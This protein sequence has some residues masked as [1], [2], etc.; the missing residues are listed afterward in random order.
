MIA[1]YHT[2]T[3]RCNHALGDEREYIEN[4]IASGFQ[5][6]GFSDHAPMPFPDG[7]CSGFRMRVEQTGEYVETLRMLQKEYE[8]D[9]RILIGFEAEYYPDV[10]QDFLDL[11]QPFALDYLI[12]GQHALDNEVN[13]HFNSM[14]TKDPALLKKYV[15]Q[16]IAGLSTGKFLYH[17]H[18]DICRFEGDSAVFESEITRYLTFCK[19]HNIPIEINLLGLMEDR[20]YPREDLWKLAGKIGVQA[21]IGC[22]A[23]RPEVM[24]DQ[25]LH[26][27]GI[28]WAKKFGVP[29]LSQ[30][31]I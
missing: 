26:Q 4:A 14:P 19:E 31:P 9:I 6:L 16:V 3:T 21:I 15:D 25:V 30:L 24:S 18:P 29:L 2:H 20:W 13:A 27:K 5:V 22:D 11:I 28:D 10:F 17:A 23:H 12:L 8:K 7:Y 1:N